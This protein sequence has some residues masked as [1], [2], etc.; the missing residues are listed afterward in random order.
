MNEPRPA[1]ESVPDHVLDEL[2]RAFGTESEPDVEPMPEPVPESMPE[3]EPESEPEPDPDPASEPEVDP[4]VVRPEPESEQEVGADV[5]QPELDVDPES[6]PEPDPETGIVEPEPDPEPGIIEAAPETDIESE[7]TPDPDDRPTIVIG[8]DDDEQFPEIVYLD[9]LTDGYPSGAPIVIGNELDSSGALDPVAL[10][11]RSM[12]PRV[13]ERRIAVKR[14]RARR[15]LLVVGSIAGAVVAVVAVVAVLASSLFSVDVV[16]VQGAPYTSARNAEELQAV[17]DSLLGEPVLLVDTDAARRE[18]E[19]IPWVERAFVTTDFPDRVLI[20][21]RER[22]PL[23]AFTGS[24]MRWRVIDRDGRV[25]DILDGQPADYMPIEG[26]A[27]DS[28]P[29]QLAGTPFALAA[30]LVAALPAE[31]RDRTE[32]VTVDAATGDFGLRL[33]GPIEVR[34]G[35]F[36]RMDTK[37]AR[38]LQQVRDGLEGITGIDVATDEIAVTSS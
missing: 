25:L 6:D 5:V 19:Q 20:D 10:P 15:R 7:T 29:G 21:I 27:P 32:A 37:L 18:L 36:D 35:G 24:D 22:R 28:E 8:G 1:D 30:Q 3:P 26:L 17:V 16:D 13:R 14:E 9:D 31:I 11:A 4:D 2:K 23:A 38:L 12:D 34:L 33:Q